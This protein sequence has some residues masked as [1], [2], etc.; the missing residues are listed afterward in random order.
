MASLF[1]IGNRFDLIASRSFVESRRHS[2]GGFVDEDGVPSIEATHA[3]V[4]ALTILSPQSN[5][6]QDWGF[7]R[8]LLNANGFA[9]SR[10]GQATSIEATVLFFELLELIGSKQEP[11]IQTAISLLKSWL[12]EREVT[13]DETLFFADAESKLEPTV[14]NSLAIRLAILLEHDFG[15]V[16]QWVDYF[17]LLQDAESGC[18][19]TGP[20]SSTTSVEA[21]QQGIRALAGLSR[22]GTGFPSFKQLDTSG[23]HECFAQNTAYSVS[24]VSKAHISLAQTPFVSNYF[25]VVTHFTT[26]DGKD[27]SG[28]TVIQGEHLVP[29]VAIRTEFGSHPDLQVVT[30][31]E[32]QELRQT[33][34]LQLDPQ[35]FIWFGQ[36]SFDTSTIL[37]HF[38]VS[39][40]IRK[41]L[42]F[43]HTIMFT[44][45][46]VKRIGYG[47]EVIPEAVFE[48]QPI[49]PGGVVQSG[50][51]FRMTINL[52]TIVEPS[53]THGQ[54]SLELSIQESSGA[55]IHTDA[56]DGED[57]EGAL[58]FE[59]TLTRSDIL[60]G[61]LLFDFT[62]EG[63]TGGAHSRRTLAYQID[64]TLVAAELTLD[65]TRAS[66]GS[67]VTGHFEPVII[68]PNGALHLPVEHGH[69]RSFFLDLKTRSGQL[70]HSVPGVF[71]AEQG[72]YEF[73]FTVPTT[74]EMLGQDLAVSVRYQMASKGEVVLPNYDVEAGSEASDLTLTIESQ[75]TFH[76][77]GAVP[78]SSFQFGDQASWVF[79]IVDSHSGFR[80]P[81]NNPASVSRSGV[82][83]T[84]KHDSYTSY[85]Y[86]VQVQGND[87]VGFWIAGPDSPAGPATLAIEVFD[88][89]GNS[90][91]ISGESSVPIVISGSVQA[92]SAVHS[93]SSAAIG[94]TAFI[95]DFRL[96]ASGKDVSDARIQGAVFRNGVIFPALTNVPVARTAEGFSA[97]WTLSLS[98]ARSGQYELRLLRQMEYLSSIEDGTEP[99]KVA[100]ALKPVATIEF[101]HHNSNDFDIGI[102]IHYVVL[103]I[104]GYLTY[105]V[106]TRYQGKY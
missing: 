31:F 42:P 1:A 82:F 86:P 62:V 23:F 76:Q 71:S 58:Y 87:L 33:V 63:T 73:S 85:R 46:D 40:H 47:I 27:L 6:L 61:Q 55:V 80:L 48:G 19:F 97:T 95:A 75:L 102:P 20:D 77:I 74:V 59:F 79:A 54:F 53:I 49:V 93:T 65:S 94:R 14:F 52:F 50:T 41:P 43:I 18:I 32:H 51:T 39:T 11:E 17:K 35:S 36:G 101:S 8:T 68:D 29:S 105:F 91:P 98:D 70:I 7:V 9:S 78:T 67:R 34:E 45:R 69:R 30:T 96:S 5:F 99:H 15:R 13:E 10:P 24:A 72:H 37:G 90:L 21:T 106:L 16:S 26:P 12:T 83:I 92:T 81:A 100:A 22:V 103:S 25:E 66:L 57:A 60:P 2:T 38:G 3:G 84:V 4:S 64:N 104:F 56:I 44:R 89:D 88:V 28:E